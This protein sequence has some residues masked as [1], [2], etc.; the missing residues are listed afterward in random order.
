[1][2]YGLAHGDMS[3]IRLVISIPL[4]KLKTSIYT[5]CWNVSEGNLRHL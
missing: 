4:S 5:V 3:D 2:H 1:M